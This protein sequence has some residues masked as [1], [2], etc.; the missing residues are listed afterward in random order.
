MSSVNPLYILRT[1]IISYFYTFRDS[2]LF[3]PI[4]FVIGGFILFL[5]TSRI[6]ESLGRSFYTDNSAAS[7]YL[8]PLI[9]AGSPNAARSILST[10]ATGWAT[11]LGVTFSVTLITLQLAVTRYVS[12][13]INEFQS[14]RTNQLAIAWF[15]L[16]V[17]YSLF[18]LKTVRTG[19]D[20][21]PT[22]TPILGVN[23]SVYLAAIA[24][25]VFV[26]FLN[27]ITSYLK[28]T[29]L[30]ERIVEKVQ[31]SISLYE[32]RV[33][34]RR[35]IFKS[36]NHDEKR[37][38]MSE[39]RSPKSGF[40]RSIDW[41]RISDHI[42]KHDNK[43][44]K[45]EQEEPLFLLEWFT[46]VGGKVNKSETIAIMSIYGEASPEISDHSTDI[47]K[48]LE[49]M[50]QEAILSGLKIGPSRSVSTDPQYGLEI[51]RNMA[52]KATNQSD[53]ATITSCVS[54]LFSILYRTLRQG[55]L[56][57][58][59]FMIP[60][61]N[62]KNQKNTINNNR[63]LVTSDLRERQIAEEVLAEL[64]TI[65]HISSKSP[66]CATSVA[67]HFATNYVGAGREILSE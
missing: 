47:R 16:T 30:I 39:I 22:F 49:R 43:F 8:E 38:K 15:I 29:L 27:N 65:Y 35:F 24:L 1:H 28:P 53:I 33:P 45:L 14:S 25:F 26:L 31:R 36:K 21:I 23:L 60:L 7:S 37:T 18:V 4:I 63:F 5:L 55:Y 19:E 3:Y 62:N 64:S 11:I 61:T 13:L 54:G 40:I 10:V 34:D 66:E 32:S 2:F 58:T 57:G 17:T 50:L 20:E 48:D 6:D 9:F 51:I 12:E 44:Q 46:P 67:E 56:A 59:P 42:R 52:A 41:E